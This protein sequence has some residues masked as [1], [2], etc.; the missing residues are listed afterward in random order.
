MS[1]TFNLSAF[2]HLN[3]PV[4]RLFSP[5]INPKQHQPQFAAF[6]LQCRRIK[7]IT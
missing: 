5:K 4:T 1:V 3:T 7:P 2:Y 6:T